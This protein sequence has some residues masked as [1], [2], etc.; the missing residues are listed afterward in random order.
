MINGSN[1]YKLGDIVSGHF[2]YGCL[3]YVD[4][5][6]NRC[7]PEKKDKCLLCEHLATGKNST[8]IV[9]NWLVLGKTSSFTQQSN[10]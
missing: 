9:G 7:N 3:P 6:A 8:A 5:P 10:S 4:R 1:E 2:C